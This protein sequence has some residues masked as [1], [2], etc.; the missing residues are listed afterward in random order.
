MAMAAQAR[1]RSSSLL[2]SAHAGVRYNLR[3]EK[4][5]SPR[6]RC[7]D[8][9]EVFD[10]NTHHLFVIFSFATVQNIR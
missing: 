4:N 6:Y 2:R 7:Q 10:K 8:A 9:H 5:R 1:G 3:T